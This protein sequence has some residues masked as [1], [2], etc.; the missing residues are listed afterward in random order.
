MQILR[1]GQALLNRLYSL[2][3]NQNRWPAACM[4]AARF[5]R[6]GVRRNVQIPEMAVKHASKDT[7]HVS[8]HLRIASISAVL[9]VMIALIAIVL[10]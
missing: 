9:A 7:D 6:A 1:Q 3:I 8:L 5:V 10:L 4:I 2:D